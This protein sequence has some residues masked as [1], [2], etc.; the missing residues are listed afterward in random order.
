MS[1]Q[2][3]L[4]SQIMG[5]TSKSSLLYLAMRHV[6]H[7]VSDMIGRP[8]EIKDLRLKIHSIN[9]MMVYG[10]D[11]EAETVGIYLRIS[12]DLPGEAML[13]LSLADAMYLADWLLELRPGSTTFL[14]D[15]ERSA[16]AEVG[17]LTL[18]SFLNA[19]A[20]LT[21]TP[22]APS[23]PAVR[24]DM[25]ATLLQ[26]AIT[27]LAE[28]VDE[29]LILET[30]IVNIQSELLIQFWLLPDPAVIKSTEL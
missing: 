8:L 28:P 29:L 14:G 1:K 25:L 2:N 27:L 26:A 15:M 20:D 4:W 13:I 21:G 18:S 5:N 10:D 16:L 17:N 30:E 9:E 12:N 22:L 23:P 24:V 11:P 3:K 6:S 7:T 19:I